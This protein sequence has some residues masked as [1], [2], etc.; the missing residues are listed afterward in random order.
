MTRGPEP[1]AIQLDSS[2]DHVALARDFVA[3]IASRVPM[4]R[5]QI[6]D[7]ELVVT[8]A[9]TNV[10]EHGYQGQEDQPVELAVTHQDDHFTIQIRHEGAAFDPSTQADPVMQEYLAQRRVGGLGLLLMK[11]LMDKVE[12]TTDESGKRVILLVKHHPGT[13]TPKDFQ[14]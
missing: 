9:L 10:M 6:H 14:G 3:D 13:T 8:E 7:L 12:Y 2:L 4:N 11:K 5:Q 1:W